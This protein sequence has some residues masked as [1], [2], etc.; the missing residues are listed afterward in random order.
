MKQVA[1]PK[2]QAP[3]APPPTPAPAPV[4]QQPSAAPDT[5]YITYCPIHHCDW[6]QSKDMRSFSHPVC[7][8]D[9]KHPIDPETGHTVHSGP[10]KLSHNE[11]T[12]RSYQIWCDRPREDMSSSDFWKLYTNVLGFTQQD[13]DDALQATAAQ[14]LKLNDRATDDYGF[15]WQTLVVAVAQTEANDNIWDQE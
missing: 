7:E 9:C 12:G 1:R 11:K 5:E 4:Q 6:F 15:A 13:V 14:L 2:P 10:T 8:G 3:S